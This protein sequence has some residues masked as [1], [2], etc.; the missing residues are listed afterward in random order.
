MYQSFIRKS[1]HDVGTSLGLV[2][3][4]GGGVVN[5]V[6]L[7]VLSKD[8]PDAFASLMPLYLIPPVRNTD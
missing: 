2:L 6:E 1:V 8:V 4:L 7:D 5:I 3:P